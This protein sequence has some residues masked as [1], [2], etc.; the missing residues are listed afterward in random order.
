MVVISRW[1]PAP[2]CSSTTG[3]RCGER[4]TAFF[5]AFC[6]YEYDDESEAAQTFDAAVRARSLDRPLIILDDLSAAS[7]A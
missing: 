3:S 7:A 6:S 2:S 5:A 4:G 1:S